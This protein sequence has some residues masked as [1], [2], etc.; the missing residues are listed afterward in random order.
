MSEIKRVAFTTISS[1]TSASLNGP[2]GGASSSSLLSSASASGGNGAIS[3]MSMATSSAALHRFGVPDP[4]VTSQKSTGGSSTTTTTTSKLNKTIRLNMELFASNSNSFPEFNYSKLIHLEKKK[5]KKL[6]SNKQQNGFSDPFEENDD[7]VARIAKELEKKYGT[8]YASG[9]G[10]S[11]KDDFCDIG[12]GYD[13]NDSFIDNTEA[14]DEIIP[15]EVETVE[16]G[17]YINS[18]ALVFK[19]LSCTEKTDEIIKMPNK[20]RKRALSTSSEESGSSEDEKDADKETDGPT[21]TT[22]KS[23]SAVANPQQSAISKMS[24]NSSK[25]K[26]ALPTEKRHKTSSDKESSS[27]K[28]KS[29]KSKSSAGTSGATSSVTSLASGSPKNDDIASE[30]SSKDKTRVDRTT[31]KTTTVKDMLKAKRDSFLKMQE[32]E[33][34]T[35]TSNGDA[36]ATTTSTEDLSGSDSSS[37][38]SDSNQEPNAKKL[39]KTE[40]DGDKLRP[41]DTELPDLSYELMRDVENIKD[42]AKASNRT[43]KKFQFD[44]KLTEI[45]LSVDD[46]CLCLDKNVRNNVFAHLE[47]QLSLPKYF[48]LRKAK[49]LRINQE[50]TKTKKAFV[51]LRKAVSEIMQSIH[52]QYQ[53]NLTKYEEFQALNPGAD[54]H[55][56]EN[57]PKMP[58][59]R[60][61]WNDTT[62]SLLYELYQ[63]RWMSFTV[64]RTRKESFEDFVSNFL[65]EKVINIWPSG[66]MKLEEI[67]REIEKKKNAPKKLKENKKPE[68]SLPTI[69]LPEKSH[70]LNPDTAMNSG[71]K[72]SINTGDNHATVSSNEPTTANLKPNDMTKLLPAHS[73]SSSTEH[74][75]SSKAYSSSSSSGKLHRSTTNS[76]LNLCSSQS[77]SKGEKSSSGFVINNNNNAN[78]NQNLNSNRS[79][80]STGV[81]NISNKIPID[82]VSPSKRTDHS[83]NSI[84]SSP[85]S[86]SSSVSTTPQPQHSAGAMGSSLNMDNNTHVINI[87]NFKS[88]SEI[89]NTSNQLINHT[90][91]THSQ[92]E[93]QKGRSSGLDVH[94]HNHPPLKTE[95]IRRDSSSESDG[96][97]IVGVYQ[98]RS[99]VPSLP[100]VNK[101]KY[102]KSSHHGSRSDSP[103][104]HDKLKTAAVASKKPL[105]C[106]DLDVNK[107]MKAL[108]ELE[109]LQQT[110]NYVPDISSF[111]NS[112]HNANTSP[113]AYGKDLTQ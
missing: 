34:K 14:Y 10:R 86:T 59:K 49:Q 50:K 63:V 4:P 55:K 95:F 7:D 33:L 38:E 58:K 100:V 5:L 64:L 8:T 90:S 9:R 107:I 73:N 70:L 89:I 68:E 60:F 82:L 39:K 11:K 108:K 27:D 88:A 65:K 103:G 17:F 24:T 111:T 31:V 106:T 52:Q 19:Q 45:F 97:E 12:L 30:S 53:T 92:N 57:A 47:Y 76:P 84:M 21:T 104:L 71:S 78:P 18:G 1:S 66:W 83:I 105:E 85:S 6:K 37:D 67:K 61:Q 22:T 35:K 42:T 75:H 87:D 44:D 56:L 48:L 98:A 40:E 32:E 23:T 54:M 112:N 69:T 102:K 110:G 46:R 13:E 80:S 41:S 29:S 26:T 36:K 91:K 77:S 109:E 28:E 2:G 94:P 16:G 25:Q 51:K 20:T 81:V 74:L 15:E 43:G 99:S 96:V 72:L 113:L 3:S 62:R 101:N 93:R 79:S